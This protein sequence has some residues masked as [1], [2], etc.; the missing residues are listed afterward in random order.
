V[1]AFSRQ[2][3]FRTAGVDV[4]LPADLSP[5]AIVEQAAPLLRYGSLYQTLAAANRELREQSLRDDLT[6]LPNRRH[7]SMDLKRNVEMAR[8]IG[9]PLS[10]IIVDIDNFKRINDTYGHPAGDNVIRQFGSVINRAKRTSDSVARLGGDE[11]AWLLVDAD[12]GRALQAAARAQRLVNDSTFEAEDDRFR[13]TA[14]FGVSSIVP[15]AEL[16]ADDLVG[17]ADRALYWGKESGKNIVRFYPPQRP[18]E[19]EQPDAT[20]NR[21]IS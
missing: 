21:Y 2:P 7:F 12:P 20:P 5:E 17:N 18:E 1:S 6:G 16:S 4:L 13:V 15:G 11:F 9:R 10:C 14:T 8:R 3:L 19:E